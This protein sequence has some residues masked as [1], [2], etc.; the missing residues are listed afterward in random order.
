MNQLSDQFWK[1]SAMEADKAVK[2][3]ILAVI[4][5]DDKVKVGYAS[6]RFLCP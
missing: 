2:W 6:G 4:P 3:A 1:I 5:L